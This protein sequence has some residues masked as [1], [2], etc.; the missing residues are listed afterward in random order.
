MH[1]TERTKIDIDM[2]APSY[3]ANVRNK[4]YQSLLEY[5]M[6]QY[7]EYGREQDLEKCKQII[8]DID[9]VQW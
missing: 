9:Q 6:V 7:D 8:V 5:Y 4:I 2:I 1:L 3:Y